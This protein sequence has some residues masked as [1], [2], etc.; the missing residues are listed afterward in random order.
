[1][2]YTEETV[3]LDQ[4]AASSDNVRAKTKQD[5]DLS[6][7]KA[8]IS[9]HGL[10]SPLV[11][12]SEYR[13]VA[14]L[15]RFAALTELATDSGQE[16]GETLVPIRR[17]DA[18]ADLSAVSL[19][20]NAVRKQMDPLE[21]AEAFRSLLKAGK[22][23]DQVAA[24]F[25]CTVRYVQQRR[26]LA[27]LVPAAKKAYRAGERDLAE[28]Q[29]L[30]AAPKEMQARVLKSVRWHLDR[31]EVARA[32]GGD[33]Q[34]DLEHAL[35]NVDD[36]GV[37]YTE[38]LFDPLGARICTETTKAWRL[39]EEAI[40]ALAQSLRDSGWT[41]TVLGRGEGFYD[42]AY[43]KVKKADG[44]E[45][46]IEV[47]RD[48]EVKVHKGYKE[49]RERTSSSRSSSGSSAPK[50]PRRELT[51]DGEAYF[52]QWHHAM[53]RDYLLKN[54]SA[55]LR[56]LLAHLITGATNTRLELAGWSDDP[57][58]CGAEALR[59]SDL[60]SRYLQARAEYRD[61]VPE[62]S[63]DAED[64]RWCGDAETVR[65]FRRLDEMNDVS[66][67]IAFVMASILN[68]GGTPI[69]ELIGAEAEIDPL[70]HWCANTET[71]DH[72]KGK[73]TLDHVMADL[74]IGDLVPKSATL[75]KKR[76]AIAAHLADGGDWLPPWMRFPM[77]GYEE[78]TRPHMADSYDLLQENLNDE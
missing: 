58:G 26:K 30:T 46:L 59:N 65:V 53:A 4:L 32:L 76:A 77:A 64:H 47:S 43:R 50:P 34:F 5:D 44:G 27:T 8:S 56:W 36:A 20:E 72:L 2:S 12:D 15:R 17:L 16:P 29:A 55:A 10:I 52:N 51:S 37:A 60:V 9:A 63:F 3:R 18:G 68:G 57:E 69:V 75:A 25:G 33:Q 19:A 35:F 49:G 24:E 62:A 31:R 45:V 67:I 1:M 66:Q 6:S 7:L 38:D 74:G 61:V 22:S 41:V 73:A 28:L 48:G 71:A 13:V 21:E 39:Q 14:G 42:W 11:T 23:H 70:D 54:P 40:E 78:E